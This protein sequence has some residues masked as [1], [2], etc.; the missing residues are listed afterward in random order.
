MNRMFTILGL[1]KRY[2]SFS[3]PFLPQVCAAMTE[4]FKVP[5]LEKL[6]TAIF[7]KL[8]S[9]TMLRMGSCI[10]ISMKKEGKKDGKPPSVPTLSPLV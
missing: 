7:P 4:M 3:E 6:V 2:Y 1:F 8:L 10:G 5:D 9:A